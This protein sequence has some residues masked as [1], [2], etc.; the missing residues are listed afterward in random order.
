MGERNDTPLIQ[1]QGLEKAFKGVPVLRGVDLTIA[2]GEVAFIIGPSGGGKS[3]LLRCIN[4]LERPNAG[5]VR[6]AGKTLCEGSAGDFRIESDQELR[7]ARA[8]MPMVFQHFNLFNHMTV[9]GNVIEGPVIVRGQ[10]RQSAIA[11][12]RRLLSQFGLGEHEAKYPAQLSGGQKQRVAIVRALAMEPDAILFDEPTSAL[13]P[14]LVGDVLEAMRELAGSG[15]T[16]VIVSHEMAF[17]R[18]LADSVHFITNG[19]ITESGTA[20]A[21]F[22]RPQTVE[23]KQFMDSIQRS[24]G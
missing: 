24:G 1:V 5:T 15:L 4:F 3:T 23:L 19:R 17:A 11:T 10:S 9:L 12:A 2:R 14:Q 22:E 16:L 8:R 7:E 13:D 21:L 20:Q 6:F 18:A